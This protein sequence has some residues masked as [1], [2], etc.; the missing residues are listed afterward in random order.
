VTATLTNNGRTNL[1]S[2][3]F[4][5]KV[6]DSPLGIT[7][8]AGNPLDGEFFGRFPS[9]NRVPGGDFVAIVDALHNRI[10]AIGPSQ[11]GTPIRNNPG[12]IPGAVLP[13]TP[14][15]I[16]A[17]AL[18]KRR[19]AQ[20][21]KA[22]AARAAGWARAVARQEFAGARRA[23]ARQLAAEREANKHTAGDLAR[24]AAILSMIARANWL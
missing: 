18:L 23:A 5:V 20:K 7:D 2:G 15:E 4:T 22:N 13:P 10:L 6:F 24:E 14:A 17:A 19:E 12:A 8:V 21:A 16:A 1:G 11:Q 9:G 3:T